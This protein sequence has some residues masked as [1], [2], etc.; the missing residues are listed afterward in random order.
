LIR[1]SFIPKCSLA[2][3]SVGVLISVRLLGFILFTSAAAQV[4]VAPQAAYNFNEG[5]GTTTVDASG[6]GLTATLVDTTWTTAGK[7][8]GALSFNGSTSWVT[9]NSAP[10]LNLTTGTLE[11]WVRLS[12]LNRWSG[13]IAKGNVNTDARHNYA[14]EIDPNNL[15]NCEVGDG[16]SFTV[17]RSTTALAAGQ[18]YHLGC[19]W[20]G[21]QLRLYVNGVLNRAVTQTVNP[22]P[23]TAP[24]SIGQYG[25]N[26]DRFAGVID[27]VRI[28]S[29]ALSQAQIQ[30][31]MNTAIGTVPADTIPPVRTS[32]APSGTLATG[33]TQATLRLATNEAATCRYGIAPGISYASLP[34]VFTTTGSTTQATTVAGL[35]N[36]STY[37]Y[38]VRCSDSTGNVNTDDFSIVFSIAQPTDTTPPVRTAAQPAGILPAGT[39]QA[40][41]RLATDEPA[42]C[43]YGMAAGVPYGSLLSVFT[44]TGDTTQATTVT[45]LADG[46]TYTYYVR[47]SD[48]SGN[49]NVN[50]FSISFAVAQSTTELTAGYSIN[51]V[52]SATAMGATERAGVVPRTHWTNAAGASRT[53]PLPLNDENGTITDASVTWT[54]DSIW[55]TSVTDQAGDRRLMKGY[56]DT[57]SQRATTVSVTGLV[58]ATYDVYVY[59][60]GDNGSASRSA[61]YQLTGPGIVTT[62]VNLIDPPNTN[63]SG[64]FTEATNSSGNYVKFRING[65]GFTLTA[66]PGT[67]SDNTRRA[68]VNAIQVI[69]STIASDTTPPVRTGGQPAGTLA[70]GTTQATVQLTTDEAAA[71]RFGAAAGVAYAALPTGFTTTGGTVHTTIVGGLTN[72]AGY[73]Y[74]VRCSDTAGNVNTDDFVISFAVAQPT[75]DF[76]ISAMPS[77]RTVVQGSATFYTLTVSG[78]NGF[79]GVVSLAVAGLPS[80]AIAAF[81][82]NTVTGSGSTTLNVTTAASTPAASAALTITGTSGAT[83]HAT[84]VTLVTAAPTYSLSGTV[85]AA[86]ASATINL[87]GSVVAST[88]GNSS[89]DY[90]FAGLGNGSYTVTPSKS[91]YSFTPA[92]RSVAVTGSDLSGVDFTAVPSS[93]MVSI[94]A[95]AN[96]AALPNGF[97]IS[98]VASGDV[99]GVQFRVDG[100]DV[101]A[102]DTT[103]PYS[104]SLTAP[105][106]SHT[107]TAV[108]HNSAGGSVMSAAVTVT[109]AAGSGITLG[110]NGSQTF[111]V[112]DG[113]GVNLN[114]LSWKNGELRPALDMLTDQLGA[115]LWRV[116]FDMEDWEAINDDASPATQNWTYYNALYSNAKFQNLWGTLRYMNQKGIRTGIALSFMGRVPTWMGGSV[117][118]TSS[119]DEWV[120]MMWTLIY[121][122]KTTEHV[123]FDIVDPL[124]EPDW[125]GIEGPQVSAAQ[126]TRLLRKL[127]VA[128][129]AVGLSDVRFLG[130]NTASVSAGV[131]TY[132]PQMMADS[133]VMSRVDHF[134]LHDYGGNTGGADGAI[135]R[136]PYP[137]RNFWMTEFTAPAD[138]MSL[139]GQNPSGLQVWEAYDSVFN[140]AILAGRGS[141]PPNDDTA[142]LALIAYNAATG[143]YTPRLEFYQVEQMIKFV[144]PGSVR[145]GAS[146]SSSSLTVYAF[147][148]QGTRRVTIVGRNTSS[149]A[150]SIKG[151]LSNLPTV[152]SLQLYQTYGSNR[153]ARSG[154]VLVTGGAFFVTVQGNSYFTLTAIVP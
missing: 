134:G 58:A 74:Y 41:L 81:A 21:A 10:S 145:I 148:D 36:G 94:S 139:L 122:A 40:T 5:T 24:L 125:D 18:F 85:G 49:A 75:P 126:Y 59:V 112:M 37:T 80:G 11:A 86:G 120:E 72:G 71:C 31:D 104:V 108:A 47:C 32:G 42:T 79:G 99:T 118:N 117:I 45:N 147:Y 70:A 7:I 107:L 14:I 73:T 110:V 34:S 154:D 127:S 76:V 106:G 25:G 52:G 62:T 77:S 143:V 67:A 44:L 61:V 84:S 93:T 146:E 54:A 141:T 103:S 8:G 20:D 137:T 140:H 26:V 101:G 69:P 33:T 57:G 43:R 68:P 153:V 144:P 16:T 119:E 23:N 27:E 121:Y 152:G 4:P 111:Q 6:N 66:T 96:G 123:E 136:S 98:A 38:Y 53:T 13:V 116:C 102:E 91:G 78:T 17:V 129:D 138:I 95:P 130:P 92:A 51:F 105:A 2:L 97:S 50:D 132:I 46:N 48:A 83:S 65:T 142:G 109:V 30:T 133:D 149:S 19:T 124:N 115:T 28:Y 60:D 150:I 29:A 135:K 100:I 1:R 128:L 151:A 64:T 82:P 15:V 39:T 87:A 22:L 88:T 56:L 35:T 3:V 89:G 55:A 12:A 90:S 131:S 63:F 114:S 113:F 9:V